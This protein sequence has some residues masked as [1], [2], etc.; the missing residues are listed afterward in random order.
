MKTEPFAIDQGHTI[1][2]KGGFKHNFRAGIYLM[3]QQNLVAH[4]K[5]IV[6]FLVILSLAQDRLIQFV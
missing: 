6:H 2:K 4:F 3:P 5:P 1:T